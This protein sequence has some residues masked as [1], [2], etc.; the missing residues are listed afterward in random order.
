VLECHHVTGNF[1]YLLR[2]EVPNLGAYERFHANELAAL[3]NVGQVVTYISMA[4]LNDD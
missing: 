3:H 2:V 4:D 1:D